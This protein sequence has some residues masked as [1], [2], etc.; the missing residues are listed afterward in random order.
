MSSFDR[1]LG[2]GKRASVSQPGL[3]RWVVQS[4]SVHM[5][6][7]RHPVGSRVGAAAVEGAPL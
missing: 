7:W 5:R 6:C 3:G 4:F 2:K 1:S